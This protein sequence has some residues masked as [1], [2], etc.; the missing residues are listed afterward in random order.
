M[1]ARFRMDDPVHGLSGIIETLQKKLANCTSELA[2]VNQ[3]NQFHRQRSVVEQ[4]E[5]H[6]L[7]QFQS[8]EAKGDSSSAPRAVPSLSLQQIDSGLAVSLFVFAN[9]PCH[10]MFLLKV[11]NV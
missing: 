10:I 1:E 3:Q 11:V 8:N 4:Q 6:Q 9:V 5:L 2:I 7:R